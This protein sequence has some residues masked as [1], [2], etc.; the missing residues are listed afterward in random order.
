VKRAPSRTARTLD[1]LLL[2]YQHLNAAR[3]PH[4]RFFPTCSQYAREA[5][6]DHGALRGSGLTLR[7]LSR[8]RP[9]GGHGFDPVP[10]APLGGRSHR[11]RAHRLRGA[12]PC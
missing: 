7:R 4:C 1:R 10:E 9:L 6:A 12:D 5:I 11:T 2:A 8:C 3:L